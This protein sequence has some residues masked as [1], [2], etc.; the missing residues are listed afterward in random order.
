MPDGCS[1]PGNGGICVGKWAQRGLHNLTR[2]LASRLVSLPYYYVPSAMSN[3]LATGIR[4][5][6]GE[7]VSPARLP[8]AEPSYLLVCMRCKGRTVSIATGLQTDPGMPPHSPSHVSPQLSILNKCSF[9]WPYL[10]H[11]STC[12]HSYCRLSS[13]RRTRHEVCQALAHFEVDS[14]CLL[15]VIFTRREWQKRPCQRSG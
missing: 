1:A 2:R 8:R 9:K 3:T 7:L 6:R 14:V 11:V 12:H 13:C 4:T 10:G 5:K 15:R